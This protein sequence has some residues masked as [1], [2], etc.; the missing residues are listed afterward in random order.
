MNI[1]QDFNLAYELNE[2]GQPIGLPVPDW[3]GVQAPE[4]ITLDGQFCR[5]EPLNIDKHARQLFDANNTE[6]TN[7]LWTY[8]PNGPFRE[9]NDYVQWLETNALGLNPLFYAIIDRQSGK[10]VGVAGY[11]RIEPQFGSIEV[12]HICYSP[13]LA[14]TVA[15]TEAMYLMMKNIFNMGYRRYEWKCNALNFPSR[16]AA[17]RLGF[18]FEG[19]FRNSNVLKGRNRDTAWFSITDAE[20]SALNEVFQQWLSAENFQADG[21]QKTSLS[22]LTK[23]LLAAL[24][25]IRQ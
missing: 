14:K 17:Q 19:I 22:A 21:T 15:A 10:A 11:L 6:P 16:H 3:Q 20:W 4:K 25:N 23:P 18:S 7:R 24:D 9:F 12:G 8:L 13:L 5:L 1:P 2:L